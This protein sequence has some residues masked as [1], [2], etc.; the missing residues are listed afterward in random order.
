MLDN[1][2]AS[3]FDYNHGSSETAV[4]PALNAG[5]GFW[6]GSAPP[7]SAA[8]PHIT[9]EN[10][11][12]HSFAKHGRGGTWKRGGSRAPRDRFLRSDRK[13]AEVEEVDTTQTIGW[14]FLCQNH[15]FCCLK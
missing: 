4:P 12:I 15:V 6:Q 8:P 5:S 1:A 2:A 9:P 7:A 13:S 14:C 3:T 11:P 10:A